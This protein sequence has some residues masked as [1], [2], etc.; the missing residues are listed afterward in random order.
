M[1]RSDLCINIKIDKDA[2]TLTGSDNGIGMTQEKMEK[3]LGLE[4]PAE[5]KDLFC[6]LM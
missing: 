1:N 3:N 2:R 5:Y 4:N 6:K